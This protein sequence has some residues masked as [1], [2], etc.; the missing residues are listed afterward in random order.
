MSTIIVGVLI[1][2]V[3]YT[4][5]STHEFV[6]G[7]AAPLVLIAVGLVYVSLDFRGHDHHDHE[8]LVDTDVSSERSRFAI[9]IPLATALFFSPCMAMGSYFFLAGT[10]GWPSIVMVSVIYLIVTVLGLV[11]MVNLALR[12]MERIEW[13]FLEEHEHFITG[14]V[15]IALGVLVHLVE[16]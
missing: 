3:G 12:G 6:M 2:I 4:L 15:L 9:A 1:G 5:S 14:I 7:V 10:G 8:G 13:H 16:G 11:L